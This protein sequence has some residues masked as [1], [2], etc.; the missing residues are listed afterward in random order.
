MEQ[1]EVQPDA[2]KSQ[3]QLEKDSV[4]AQAY[5]CL[6]KNNSGQ[7]IIGVTAD[8]KFLYLNSEL[9]QT[10]LRIGQN[11]EIV[12]AVYLPRPP[13]PQSSPDSDEDEDVE[14]GASAAKKQKRKN[15][16]DEE[17]DEEAAAAA[18][19]AKAA[20]FDFVAVAVNSQQVRHPLIL[21]L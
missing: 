6:L 20:E 3:Q 7:G 4:S 21:L 16:P 19:A 10:H 8:R 9:Q 13:A 17:M 5:C 1:R 11:D 18:A 2:D 15:Q 14:G 12:D